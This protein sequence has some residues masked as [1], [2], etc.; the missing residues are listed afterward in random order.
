[1][2]KSK[3]LSQWCKTKGY[4]GVNKDCIMNAFNSSDENVSRMAKKEKLKGVVKNGKI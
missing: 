1:M 4:G 3:T 2:P